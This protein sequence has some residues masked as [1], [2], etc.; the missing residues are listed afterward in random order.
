MVTKE[1]DCL[2]PATETPRCYSPSSTTPLAEL[3]TVRSIEIVESSSFLSPVWYIVRY[4]LFSFSFCLPWN[5]WFWALLSPQ[6]EEKCLFVKTL[7]LCIQLYMSKILV[8]V[9]LWVW[10]LRHRHLV[11]CCI[12]IF[13]NIIFQVTS[14]LLHH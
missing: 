13:L 9:S 7:S 12:I 8:F 2:P 3:K 4:L 6:S 5:S 10:T 11:T 1:E 14:D